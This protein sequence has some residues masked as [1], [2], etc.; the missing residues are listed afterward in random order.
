MCGSKMTLENYQGFISG[1]SLGDLSLSLS[2]PLPPPLPPPAALFSLAI[3]MVGV[4]VS[5][6]EAVME[7]G[8]FQGYSPVVLL[9]ICLQVSSHHPHHHS[10]QLVSVSGDSAVLRAAFPVRINS[11]EKTP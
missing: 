5:D 11:H 1:P 7:Y 3:G 10:S 6:R 9:V 4:F 8:F 2:L